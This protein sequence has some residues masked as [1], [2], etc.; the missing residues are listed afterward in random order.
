M[1]NI[2]NLYDNFGI[3]GHCYNVFGQY[4]SPKS[5]KNSCIFDFN[6]KNAKIIKSDLTYDIIETVYGRNLREYSKNLSSRAGLAEDTLFFYDSIKENY[7]SD[8]VVNQNLFYAT[9]TETNVN[10]R[11]SMEINDIGALKET[12]NN[13]FREEIDSADP[14]FL[15]E[16]YGTHF[17]ASAYMGTRIDFISTSQIDEKFDLKTLLQ[18][19]DY[20]FKELTENIRSKNNSSGILENSLTQ[21]KFRLLV[22][23]NETVINTNNLRRQNEYKKW[24]NKTSIEP[25]LCNFD[26]DSLY[27]IWIFAEGKKRINLLESAF[28]KMASN[29]PLPKFV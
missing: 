16:K 7:N 12:L 29:Y 5:I 28:R 24:I 1:E 27:P 18:A 10:S 21:S 11:I 9:Y 26:K 8:G 17:I 25:V 3:I 23:N 22:G 19:I 20:K 13:E 14:E 15:F 2:C 6:N 4:A